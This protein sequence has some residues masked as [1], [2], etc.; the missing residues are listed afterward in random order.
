M[1][2]LKALSNRILTH[3]LMGK[4]DDLTVLVIKGEGVKVRACESR[5]EP[6]ATL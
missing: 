6:T 1:I 2:Q 5:R 4:R 3:E